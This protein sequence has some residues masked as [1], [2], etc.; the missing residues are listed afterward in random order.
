M[1]DYISTKRTSTIYHS[2]SF[3][4]FLPSTTQHTT[5]TRTCIALHNEY[6]SEEYIK[7][8]IIMTTL[9]DYLPSSS[10]YS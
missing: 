9:V 8:N 10:S 5:I 6:K 2:L 7:T 4:K 1:F 3:K